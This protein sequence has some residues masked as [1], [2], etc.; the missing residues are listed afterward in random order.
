MRRAYGREAEN[1][2]G[3]VALEIH[4]ARTES[5]RGIQRVNQTFYRIHTRVE[6][7]QSSSDGEEKRKKVGLTRNYYV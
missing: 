5:S 6:S 1:L 4:G 3:V 2:N 7:C